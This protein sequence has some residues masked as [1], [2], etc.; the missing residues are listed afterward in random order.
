[1]ARDPRKADLRDFEQ[2]RA[3]YPMLWARPLFLEGLHVDGEQLS[4]IPLRPMVEWLMVRAALHHY[5]RFHLKAGQVYVQNVCA[6]SC[7]LIL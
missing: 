3:D 2:L 5:G 1:M 4:E 6:F 7:V